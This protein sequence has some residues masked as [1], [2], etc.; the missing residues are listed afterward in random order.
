MLPSRGSVT[1]GPPPAT[2]DEVERLVLGGF[3]RPGSER[4]LCSGS[5]GIRENPVRH[6]LVATRCSD[7]CPERQP[8][9]AG[10]ADFMS[11]A[12][13]HINE[14]CA[15][16]KLN[17]MVGNHIVEARLCPPPQERVVEA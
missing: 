16:E 8:W 7:I 3:L 10:G 2:A 15:F 11:L 4:S 9:F 6:H 17:E 12:G 14:P 1:I 5:R 13:S